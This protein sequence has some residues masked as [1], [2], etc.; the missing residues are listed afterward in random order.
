M[1]RP[2]L[3]LAHALED[4]EAQR[5]N[6]ASNYFLPEDRLAIQ[7]APLSSATEPTFLKPVLSG[8]PLAAFFELNAWVTS[9]IGTGAARRKTAPGLRRSLLRR[10]VEWPLSGAFGD[11]VEAR[12]SRWFIQRING[13]MRVMPM[14]HST[15]EVRL[16]ARVYKGHTKG[17]HGKT[18]QAW[19]ER[20]DRLRDLSGYPIDP[21]ALGRGLGSQPLNR[22]IVAQDPVQAPP[23]LR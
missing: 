19:H 14:G 18:R 1:D 4:A 11:R 3:R 8:E 13:K 21:V 12:I 17:N 15:A 7:N 2:V 5:E 23:G 9:S 22:S 10:L 20:V 16:D 6:L